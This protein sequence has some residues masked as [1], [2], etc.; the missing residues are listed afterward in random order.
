VQLL[1]AAL[2]LIL[3][4]AAGVA[5][6]VWPRR[7]LYAAVIVFAVLWLRV[8][9]PLEGYVLVSFGRD[10]G[11]TLGDLLV[12]VEFLLIAVGSSWKRRAL[13]SAEQS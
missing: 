4:V 1:M 12:P 7:L 6:L 9:G 8:N 3:F 2:V 13:A 11:L 5:A 10:N